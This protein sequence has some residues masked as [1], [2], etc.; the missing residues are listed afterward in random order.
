MGELQRLCL[1]QHPISGAEQAA[2]IVGA[3]H[4]RVAIVA[5]DRQTGRE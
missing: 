2:D 4:P 1:E 5:G 3:F